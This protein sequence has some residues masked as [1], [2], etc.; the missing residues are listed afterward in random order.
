MGRGKTL[1]NTS[2]HVCNPQMKRLIRSDGF[3]FVNSTL[4]VVL[5]LFSAIGFADCVSKPTLEMFQSDDPPCYDRSVQPQ[6]AVVDTHLHFRP[7]GG[8][9]VRFEEI[10]SH[11][12]KTGVLFANIMALVRCFP[13]SRRAPITWIVPAR[14]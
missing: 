5:L 2:N 14:R 1:S 3:W 6:T 10:V 7:F 8:P 12:E 13:S 4:V 11:L 9:A